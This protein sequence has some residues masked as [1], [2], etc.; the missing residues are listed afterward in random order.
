MTVGGFTHGQIVQVPGLSKQA[1]TIGVRRSDDGRL[2][3]WFHAKGLPGAGIFDKESLKKARVTGR[4]V[5][6]PRSCVPDTSRAS[7]LERPLPE[8]RAHCTQCTSLKEELGTERKARQEAEK[9]LKKVNKKLDRLR[10]SNSSLLKATAQGTMLGERKDRLKRENIEK[11]LMNELI[12]PKLESLRVAAESVEKQEEAHRE[13]KA[14]SEQLKLQKQQLMQKLTE[15]QQESRRLREA[16]Q[17][18]ESDAAQLQKETERLGNEI[19]RQ[20]MEKTH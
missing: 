6:R 13:I 15:N 5:V 2:L 20:A 17:Q 19:S 1:V 11:E 7:L 10:A 3:L 12:Q 18:R 4:Q 9:E 14:T 8:A 16:L